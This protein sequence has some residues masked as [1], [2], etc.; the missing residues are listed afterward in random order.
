MR[1]RIYIEDWLEF[2]PYE[3]QTKTDSYYLKICN[4]VGDVIRKTRQSSI[5]KEDLDKKTVRLLA[6]F[7]TAYLE[8]IISETNIWN[9]FIKAHKRLYKKPLPFFILDEYCQGE[10]NQQD[11]KF[12][13]WYFLNTI[14]A[15]VIITP[16][17]SAIAEIADEVIKVFNKAQDYAP[18]NEYLKFFYQIDKNE[19]NFY[20]ARNL[21]EAILFGTYLFYP[22]SLLRLR[23]RELKILKNHKDVEE[24]LPFLSESKDNFL[25]KTHTQLLSLKGKEWAATILGNNHSL[26]KHFLNM[27]QKISGYFLYQGQDDNDVFIEHIASSKKFKL[28]KKSFDHYDNLKEEDTILFIGIVQWKN[29]WWFSGSFFKRSFEADLILDE[30]NSLE[31]RMEVNFLDHQKKNPYKLLN[32]QLKA[33]KDFNKGSQIA[34]MPSEKIE[35]FFKSYIEYYNN[36]LNLSAKEKK[37]AIQRIR[38]D[39]FFGTVKPHP[40]Y[41]KASKTGLVFFNPKSGVEIA[42]GVNGAFPHPNNPFFE[43]EHSK[44]DIM[45]LLTSEQMSAELALFCIDNYKNDLPFFSFDKSVGKMYLEDIDFLLRFWKR[46]HYHAKPSITYTGKS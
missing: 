12:L 16:F 10:I 35:V 14:Q 19:E 36:S 9:S 17:N 26:S 27:S 44:N 24:A 21:I 8:D 42:L 33:F 25:H 4:D 28:T 39:G 32:Q 15:K 2:K 13:T 41:G 30:K 5:L 11:I 29:E 1:K 3:K 18:K 34:F 20:V 31:S 6:C 23:E 45:G 40:D 37:A 38:Q 43:A 22:D 46:G 7:L